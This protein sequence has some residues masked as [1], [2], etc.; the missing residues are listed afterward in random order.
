MPTRSSTSTSP[1]RNCASRL[2]EG[3]IYQPEK[4]EQALTNFFRKGNLSTLRELALRAVADEVGEK[5]AS[6]RAREGLEPALIPERVMVCMS[7]NAMAPRVIRTGARIA[8]RLG[9]KWYAVYV[10]TPR[11]RPD[12][13]KA[14][15]AEALQQNIKLAESLGA[16]VV[17][18]KAD[19]PSDGLVAF[20][21]REGVTHVIFGQSARTRLGAP[22]ARIDARSIPQRRPGCRRPGRTA[23][24]HLAR[25]LMDAIPLHR[26]PTSLATMVSSVV[27][28]MEPYASDIGVKLK[29]VLDEAVP[30]TV[31]LDEDKVAW[32]IGTLI[33]NALRHV[34]RGSFFHPGGEIVVHAGREPKSGEIT[35]EVTDD[36]PGI[37]A[38]KIP[39][40]FQPAPHQRR[41]GYALILAREIVEAHGGRME[42]KSTDDPL[43]HGTTISLV[44]P[45]P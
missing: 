32:T 23:E 37:P 18:V 29:T 8:G 1:W 11:E 26:R 9:S 39:L 38:D 21:Q 36:G 27:G 24:R 19:R 15:D 7:S 16:T 28:M 22:L 2:R 43:T 44:L 41:V 3:K 40:L 10:E 13:I 42:V 4:V 5:A 6:Y 45:A 33:G 14:R 35:V 12:R 30:A 31:S 25:R 20:A 34:P 17:R